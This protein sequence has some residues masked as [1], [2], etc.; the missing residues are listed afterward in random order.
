[1]ISTMRKAKRVKLEAGLMKISY[2]QW[3]RDL[4]MTLSV[5]FYPYHFVRIILS[6]P[7]CPIPFCP[8]PFCMHTILSIPF[9]PYHFVCIPFCPNHFVHTILSVY[10]FVHTILSVYHFVRAILSGTILSG[11]RQNESF[12]LQKVIE[13][14]LN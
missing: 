9:C 1:M 13:S 3:E 4:L 7:F 6:I 14:S 10:H 5:I 8:I 11:H 2:C 12:A